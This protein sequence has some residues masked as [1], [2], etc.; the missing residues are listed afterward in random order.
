MSLGDLQKEI[1]RR[2][3][4]VTALERRRAGL[5][6]KIEAID[7]Q[8]AANGGSAGGRRGGMAGTGRTRARNETNLLDSLKEVLKGK[9]MSVTDVADAVQK[10]GY[11]TT[12]PNFR[13]IVNQ[14][15]LKKKHFK[16]V[17]R[18][19]YTAV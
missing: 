1:S 17:G 4:T 9:T 2:K 15:L 11:Q 12:S 18:G 5:L 16:R 7:A 14:T 10:A 19:Q 13:T 8:I 6:K 3:R